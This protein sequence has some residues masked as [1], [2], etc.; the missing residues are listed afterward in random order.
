MPGRLILGSKQLNLTLNRL[1]RQLIENY[2]D[3]SDTVLIGLQPRGVLLAGKVL[4]I[5]APMVKQVPPLGYLDCTFFR[6]DFRHREEPLKA[7]ETRIEFVVEGKKVILIDDVLFTGRTVRAA[8]DAMNAYGRPSHV[9]LLVL[10]DRLYTRELPIEASFTGVTVNTV[11]TQR[12][13]VEWAHL[14]HKEDT[15]W[16]IDPTV[17]R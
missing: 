11:S 13:L 4:E 16:L 17:A 12:V 3:F 9:K 2:G 1:C 8:L 5:L 7:N 15:V 6:D 14:G 10:V